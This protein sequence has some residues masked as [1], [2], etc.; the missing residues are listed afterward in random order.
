[1]NRNVQHCAVSWWTL[2]IPVPTADLDVCD[3]GGGQLLAPSNVGDTSG[4]QPLGGESSVSIAMSFCAGLVAAHPVPRDR[5]RDGVLILIDL[6]AKVSLLGRPFRVENGVV[7][8]LSTPFFYGSSRP[9]S[10]RALGIAPWALHCC[11]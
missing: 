1:M 9:F 7:V 3:V 6:L 4:D 2:S 5:A 8:A 11:R 10:S